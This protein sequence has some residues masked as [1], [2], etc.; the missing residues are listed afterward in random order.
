M[1]RRFATFEF[2]LGSPRA[3]HVTAVWLV[4]KFYHVVSCCLTAARSDGQ[5]ITHE[6]A[7]K[8]WCKRGEY[9]LDLEVRGMTRYVRVVTAQVASEWE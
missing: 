2:S 8:W 3:D 7:R 6:E 4:R 9:H 5:L 1:Q